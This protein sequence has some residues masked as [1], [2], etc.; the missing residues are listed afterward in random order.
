[1]VEVEGKLNNHPITILIYSRASYLNPILVEK[2]KLKKPS[3]V[4]IGWF[5]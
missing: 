1:M 4:G 3:M 2:F 5:S